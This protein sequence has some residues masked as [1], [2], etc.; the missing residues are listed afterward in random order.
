MKNYT[1]IFTLVFG[2]LIG[3]ASA[4]LPEKCQKTCIT[5]VT[6]HDA[7]DAVADGNPI[8]NGGRA[9]AAAPSDVSADGDAVR[10]WMLRNGAAAVTLTAAGALIPGDATN[11]LDVDITRVPFANRS[12]TYTIAAN[13]TAVD[14]STSPLKNFSISVKGTGAVPT[15]WNVRLE[16]SLDGVNFTTL[17]TH[18]EADLD[19]ATKVSANAATLYFRSRLASVTLGTA[20]NI[21]VQI[22]GM[23]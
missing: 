7:H 21:I 3:S 23:N 18:T 22:V 6:G 8:V 4:A 12:D 13:G 20:T 2:A 1:R 16:I 15:A 5:A 14:R 10:A 9:S 17:I 19:G 11:G